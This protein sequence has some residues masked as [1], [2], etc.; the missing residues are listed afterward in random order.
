MENVVIDL[1]NIEEVIAVFLG[2]VIDSLL[3]PRCIFVSERMSVVDLDQVSNDDLKK[4]VSSLISIDD[5][6]DECGQ[7]GRPSLL[8]RGGPCTRSEREPPDVILKIW[9]DFRS[10]IKSVVTMVKADWKKETE[11]SL[12]LE[13][14][15]RAMVQISGQNA[16]NMSVLVESLKAKKDDVVRPARVTKPAKVPTWTKDI[17]LETYI[18]QIE[19][20]NE[21]NED[22]PT[23]T[24]YQDFVEN[25]KMNKD[26]KGL[27]RFVGEHVLPVLEKKQ[28]QNVKKVLE[29]LDVKYGRTRIEK[30]EECVKDWLE[31]KEDQFEE[32]DELL[33]AMKEINQRRNELKI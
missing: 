6:S 32:E 14:L 11:E 4:R 1:R 30:V 23:N 18:K 10:R 22:V 3:H 27:P 19:T 28:D 33:L 15:K 9:S 29:L 21:V 7:C 2:C 5:W 25:L 26:V 8:H 20:W 12:L 24:K 17:S 16:E 13:G 31:F